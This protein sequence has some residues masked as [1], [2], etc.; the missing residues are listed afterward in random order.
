MKKILVLLSLLVL[1]ST[2]FAGPG[3][4]P[5][6]AA[7]QVSFVVPYAP[8]LPTQIVES[9]GMAVAYIGPFVFGPGSTATVAAQ[10]NA[11]WAFTS[12]GAGP[13]T[14]PAVEPANEL[15]AE[16]VDAAGTKHIVRTVQGKAEKEKAYRLRH[17]ETVKEM[18]EAFPP[19]PQPVGA[20][21]HGRHHRSDSSERTGC[22]AV[23][24]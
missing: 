12:G 16:W 15:V 18:Q 7:P 9:G 8:A 24:A 1:A 14:P 3:P 2:A 6:P 22:G 5:A 17:I 13:G 10:F 23:A 21:E 11:F 19:V 20:L 4:K